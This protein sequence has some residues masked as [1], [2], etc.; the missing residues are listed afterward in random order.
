MSREKKITQTQEFRF[1]D[2]FFLLTATKFFCGTT[3]FT[4]CIIVDREMDSTYCEIV[5]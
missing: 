2:L 5:G 4:L 3:S 1:N